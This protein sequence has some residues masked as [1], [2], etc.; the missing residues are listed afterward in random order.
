MDILT[1]ILMLMAG[2]APG[3]VLA[4]YYKK[5]NMD[6]KLL[7][8]FLIYLLSTD[9]RVTVFSLRSTVAPKP[10]PRS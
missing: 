4:Y 2:L 9:Q 5:N 3:L 8:G 7:S 6:S 10:G 1:P